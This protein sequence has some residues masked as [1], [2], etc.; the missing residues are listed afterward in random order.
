MSDG[1]RVFG[2][3]RPHQRQR[4]VLHVAPDV[5]FVPARKGGL[6]L[7]VLFPMSIALCQAINELSPQLR[8]AERLHHM[9]IGSRGQCFG[10]G[11]HFT[12]GRCH[13]PLSMGHCDLTAVTRWVLLPAAG[14]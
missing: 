12:R 2:C 14:S 5:I 7:C 1:R 10:S 3:S 9:P 13:Y 11:M 6:S 8:H 4:P